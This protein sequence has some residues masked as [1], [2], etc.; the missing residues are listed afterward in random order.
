MFTF[1]C[2]HTFSY[3]HMPSFFIYQQTQLQ[4]T[5]NFP[6]RTQRRCRPRGRERQ[7]H[8][9][10]DEVGRKQPHG[11]Y[12][13]PVTGSIYL[14]IPICT[15]PRFTSTLIVQY[16]GTDMDPLS[17]N[18]VASRLKE[19]AMSSAMRPLLRYTYTHVYAYAC[20]D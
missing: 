8:E 4:G 2:M 6:R 19:K 5:E 14:Q 13:V 9:E 3:V 18:S 7:A 12:M 20:D 16:R 1:S 17:L 15:A 10:G 11:T